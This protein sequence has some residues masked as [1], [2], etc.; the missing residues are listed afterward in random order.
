M[1]SRKI[2]CGNFEKRFFEWEEIAKDKIFRHFLYAKFI[3]FI[4]LTSNHK[5][6][7]VQL[8]I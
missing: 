2:F 8:G 7:L 6:F 5:V 4:L 3:M 1:L